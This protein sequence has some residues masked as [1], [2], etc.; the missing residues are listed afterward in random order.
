M[1]QYK[2]TDYDQSLL[3]PVTFSEQIIPGTLEY[4]INHIIDNHIDLSIFDN[5]YSFKGVQSP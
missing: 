5:D 2:S 3:I 4:A 1:A